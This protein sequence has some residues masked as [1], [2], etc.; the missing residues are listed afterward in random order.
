MRLGS[1]CDSGGCAESTVASPAIDASRTAS[2]VPCRSC[3]FANSSSEMGFKGIFGY[4][5]GPVVRRAMGRF[6]RRKSETSCYRVCD[7]AT[8]AHTRPTSSLR[9]GVLDRRSS[10]PWYDIHIAR[11][12]PRWYIAIIESGESQVCAWP[13]SDIEMSVHRSH[14]PDEGDRVIY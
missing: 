1:G 2:V 10:C 9:C 11:H 14:G 12:R 5:T 3:T 4:H 7:P 13:S 8:R 6:G